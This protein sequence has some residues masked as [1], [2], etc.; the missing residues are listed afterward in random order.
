MDVSDI[1]YF[2]LLGG[3]KGEVWSDREIQEG[4][5]VAGGGERGGR[6]GVCSKFEKG[7]GANIFSRG[8]N[9]HQ[10]LIRS[11]KKQPEHRVLGRD[12]PGTSGTQTSGYPGP[13]LY[14]SGL[15][16]LF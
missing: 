5:G 2:F 15:F 6:E 1:F 13:K 16:L 10:V 4:G 8:R 14:A 3:G 9:G 12:I 7:G 11:Q